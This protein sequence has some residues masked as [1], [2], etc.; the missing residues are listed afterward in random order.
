MT[1][2]V[3]ERL[4]GQ[5]GFMPGW[6]FELRID[7]GDRGLCLVVTLETVDFYD[8][9]HPPYSVTHWLFVPPATHDERSWSRWL[10][11]QILLV[12]RHEAME[13]FTIDGERPFPP[14]HGGGNDPYYSI[15]QF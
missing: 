9:A 10:L 11:E 3:L 15:G 14:G 5:I 7:P 13:A 2:D 12:Q 8:P 6:S 1:R 4:V